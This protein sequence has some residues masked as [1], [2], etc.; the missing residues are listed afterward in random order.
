MA[1][2]SDA[3]LHSEGIAVGL[4]KGHK[5]TKRV[6]P[7][8]PSRR[9]GALGKRTQFVRA[10]IREVTGF[11]PYERRILELLRIGKDKRA[12]KFAKRR[13]GTHTRAKRKVAEMSDALRRRA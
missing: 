4:H 13:L 6:L 12:V 8:R 5:V 2:P 3:V 10:L 11:A 1:S 7:P 9:K